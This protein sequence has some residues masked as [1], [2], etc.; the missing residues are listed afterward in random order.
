MSCIK[1]WAQRLCL[2]AGLSLGLPLSGWSQ[3]LSPITTGDLT[4]SQSST[5][6]G[7]GGPSGTPPQTMTLPSPTGVGRNLPS[8]QARQPAYASPGVPAAVSKMD[9]QGSFGTVQGGLTAAPRTSGNGV[10]TSQ[11]LVR[12]F[13]VALFDSPIHVTAAGPN[14]D[15]LISVG[16]QIMVR[17]WGSVN[18]E[19]KTNVD[20]LG[21]IFVPQVGPV[22]VAGVRAADL[23][24]Y[25]EGKIRTVYQGNVGI[26]VTLM[27]WRSIGVFVAGFVPHPGRFPGVSTESVLEYLS[28][29]GGIDEDRGSFR[30]IRVM[31]G[32]KVLA[33]IDLY[34]F[35]IDGKMPQVILRD[36]DTILVGPQ[37]PTVTVG[38]AIRNNYRFETP[39]S[40]PMSGFEL[41]RLSRPLPQA[42]HL[43]LRGTRDGQPVSEYMPLSRV[44]TRS[45]RDQDE[46]TFTADA[47]SRTLS[48]EVTGA[49][50][51]RSV[52][53]AD[54]NATLLQIL[55]H[56]EVDPNIADVSAVHI[57]RKSVARQQKSSLD[58]SLDRL[59]RSLLNVSVSTDGE[60]QVR[61]AEADLVSRYIERARTIEPDGTVVVL[62]ST[63]KI[64]NMRLEDGDEIVIPEKRTVVIVSGEVMAPQAI[65]FEKDMSARQF[66]DRSGGYSERADWG[67][68][69]LR[70]TNGQILIVSPETQ[71][72]SGDEIIVPPK[73][74]FKGFQFG[75]ELVQVM[76]QIAVS[77]GVLARVF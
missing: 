44:E 28:K 10:A 66:I 50:M 5:I 19:L 46:I 27:Q 7:D 77:A 18:A 48:I 52:F 16:D 1:L 23:P 20:Q 22:P 58:A 55:D 38:G 71:V 73:V 67:Q 4:P 72:A 8:A 39:L 13:G 25:V 68:I 62:D 57:R 30:D 56:I 69:I 40:G 49:R 34:T 36:G 9:A 14:P 31:R 54:T 29:A 2:A 6:W 64:S 42:T 11:Q 51:G 76:Y 17:I 60:A 59:E 21:N 35:L 63:G 75:K 24:S 74:E 47:V 37:R 41:M 53:M 45:F 70:K 26:Y 61:K 32:E 3:S 65:A 43:R 33:T 12:P 15:Y